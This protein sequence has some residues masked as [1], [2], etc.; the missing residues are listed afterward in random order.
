MEIGVILGD[1]TAAE[2]VYQTLRLALNQVASA[3]ET[4]WIIEIEQFKPVKV[5]PIGQG[6]LEHLPTLRQALDPVSRIAPHISV[7][8]VAA[9][10]PPA[11]L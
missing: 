3:V 1:K 4:S 8:L 2:R 5:R 11:R 10:L 6:R 7:E 9:I